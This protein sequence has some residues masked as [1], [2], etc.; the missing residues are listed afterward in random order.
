MVQERS[1]LNLAYYHLTLLKKDKT[2]IVNCVYIHVKPEKVGSF[3]EATKANHLE[4]VKEPC[5]L[6]FDIIQQA[7]DPCWFM[8]YE[9]YDSEVA[10]ANH[11]TTSHYLIWRELAEDF[12][13]EPRHGVRYNII[14]PSDRSKW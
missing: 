4:T 6:R 11:K 13:A 8:L 2:M 9:A 12:M 14:E 10:A 3:I 7:N 1:S 5:N